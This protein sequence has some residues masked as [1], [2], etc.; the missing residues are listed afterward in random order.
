MGLFRLLSYIY[1]DRNL[2]L[3]GVQGWKTP[4]QGHSP[5]LPLFITFGERYISGR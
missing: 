3:N 4:D 1:S 5:L 2:N